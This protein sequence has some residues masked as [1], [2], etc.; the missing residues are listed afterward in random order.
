NESERTLRILDYK[1]ADSAETP[2]QS[3]RKGDTWID[4]QLPLYRHLRH[5]VK[6]DVPSDCTVEL[7]YF[8]LPKN[9]DEAGVDPADWG[10]GMLAI[11]DETARN[12][13]QNLRDE[14]FEPIKYPPPDFCE[15]LAAICL[16]NVMSRPPLEDGLQGGAA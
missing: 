7:G 1:T 14:V 6:L 9:L 2:D 5:A 8:N 3:H 10:G 16:D 13:I 11:A 12:V 4:L 15:D